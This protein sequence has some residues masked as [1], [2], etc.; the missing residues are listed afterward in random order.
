VVAAPGVADTAVEPNAFGPDPSL[1][2]QLRRGTQTV[3][4]HTEATFELDRWL[5]DRASYAALLRRL[6][7]FHAAAESALDR[8]RGWD[9]LIPAVDLAARRRSLRIDQD[10]VE[11]GWPRPPEAGVAPADPLRL[12]SLA[13]GL[14][15]L[16]VIEGS[17]IGGRLIAARARAAL[18]PRLPTSFFV[19]PNRNT[20]RDWNDLRATLDSFGAG[21]NATASR[22]VLDA[23]HRTF[24]TFAA[25]VGRARP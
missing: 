4:A 9:G 11:L 17:A 8:I 3:H 18:G 1:S 19:D 5:A 7:R 6:W 2:A 25:T 22:A 24:A 12:A 10:L 21:T 20:G 16:Y 13:D 23:A 14:G 15:C